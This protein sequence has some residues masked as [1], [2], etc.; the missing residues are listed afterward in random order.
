MNA[1]QCTTAGSGNRQ[2]AVV[3]ALGTLQEVITTAGDRLTELHKRLTP[4][5][6]GEQ[7]PANGTVSSGG[8]GEHT[9]EVAEC[10]RAQA[11][12]IAALESIVNEILDRLEV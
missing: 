5:M 1:P 8:R 3:A 2:V 11:E 10:V 9:C 4:V 7:T 12:R 6:H